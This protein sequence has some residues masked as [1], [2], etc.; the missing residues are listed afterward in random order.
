MNSSLPEQGNSQGYQREKVNT[1]AEGMTNGLF[2]V[3][4]VCIKIAGR[5]ARKTCV[6]VDVLDNG[7]VLI[8]GLT[9]RRKCNPYHLEPL[10]KT[11]DVKKGAS[12]SE[13][14]S[15]LKSIG[16][17]ASGKKHSKKKEKSAAVP[18]LKKQKIVHQKSETT[19][20]VAGKVTETVKEA[21]VV[22]EKKVEKKAV[23]KKSV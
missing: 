9:R 23:E 10:S 7:F 8:D 2:E 12:H 5:D 15:A 14:V 22:K 11:V 17:E 18:R 19:K 21:K 4:R 6:V 3:G 20:P 1:M 13:V 16:I